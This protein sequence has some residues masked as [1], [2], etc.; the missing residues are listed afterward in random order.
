MAYVIIV[1]FVEKDLVKLQAKLVVETIAIFDD[2][3]LKETMAITIV[4]IF[5]I[6]ARFT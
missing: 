6:I 2:S 1:P 4:F 3:E 5:N